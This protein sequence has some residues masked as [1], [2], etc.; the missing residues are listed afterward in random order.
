MDLEPIQVDLGGHPNDE[1]AVL[2]GGEDAGDVSSVAVVVHR[3][4][5]VVDEVIA[6]GV[7]AAELRIDDIRVVVGVVVDVV[8][9]GIDDRDLHALPANAGVMR[10]FRADMGDTPGVVVLEV[11]GGL[12]LDGRLERRQGRVF[13]D[14]RDPRV[15]PEARN[16][17]RWDLDRHAVDEAECPA[18]AAAE[19]TYGGPIGRA[20]LR[21]EGDDRLDGQS[22]RGARGAGRGGSNCSGDQRGGDREDGNTRAAIGASSRPIHRH[23]SLD[24]GAATVRPRRGP[25]KRFGAYPHRLDG[26]VSPVRLADA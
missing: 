10:G 25:N 8:D 18:D 14:G 21:L 26:A 11:S 22:A 17:V 9:A 4:G 20:G 3:I 19:V 12:V 7:V 24:P 2:L 13:F 16:R 1:V 23:P 5:V 6:A 15:P